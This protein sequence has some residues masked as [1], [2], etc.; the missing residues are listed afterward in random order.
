[1]GDA[2]A[3]P[4]GPPQAIQNLIA[5]SPAIYLGRGTIGCDSSYI[6]DFPGRICI[7]S[8]VW[9]VARCRF[10]VGVYIGSLRIAI[11]LN[12]AFYAPDSWGGWR[13]YVSFL[14]Q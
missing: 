4:P 12:V 5:P 2:A 14:Y 8:D 11:S 9:G 6:R 7:S 1:M 13:F 3:P 10:L